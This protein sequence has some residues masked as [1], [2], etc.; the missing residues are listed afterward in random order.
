MYHG[1]SSAT[2]LGGNITSP[3]GWTSWST[4]VVMD[5]LGIKLIEKLGGEG[6]IF[7]DGCGGFRGCG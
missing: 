6:G 1:S 2:C 3:L 4:V 7:F 5:L